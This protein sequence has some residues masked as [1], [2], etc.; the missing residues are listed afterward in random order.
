MKNELTFDEFCEHH[1]YASDTCRQPTLHKNQIDW[2]S[3]EEGQ[4]IMDFVYKVEEFESAIDNI[5]EATDG[6]IKLIR[7][8]AN[9]NPFSKSSDYKGMY[10]DR[11]RKLILRNFEKDIDYF[12]YTF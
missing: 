7:K 2:L 8:T 1:F 11:T 5:A 10:N 9:Q 4:V 3:D 6:R 12:K